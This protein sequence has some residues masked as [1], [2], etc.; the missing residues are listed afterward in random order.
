MAIS[1]A[2]AKVLCSGTE[3]A[4][5]K[6]SS[7]QEIGT[8]T[9]ARLKQKQARARKLRDK[10]R[11]Q[12]ASQRRTAKSKTGAAEGDKNSAEKAA[13]FEEVLAR[14]TAQLEKAESQGKSAGPMG[15]RR[16]T[17]TAR[18]RSHRAER[19][20]V[21]GELA[22]AKADIKAKGK[23]KKKAA[24][25]KTKA[26]P[27]VAAEPV[28]KEAAAAPT[29]TSTMVKGGDSPPKPKRSRVPVAAGASAIVAGREAQGLHVT[30]LGQLNANATAKQNRLKASGLVR[31]Q[32]NRS[33]ANKR[34]QGRRDS[35]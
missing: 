29:V 22:E 4:L 19:A 32:K 28:A 34:S 6:A 33:A 25:A 31:I 30:K 35:R 10:W 18:S 23:V 20:E 12:V 21:R 5:V 26:K 11:D 7:K 13:L 8:H 1:T 24:P 14:F 17:K 27:A 15:R 2:R 3:L 16:S 9:A